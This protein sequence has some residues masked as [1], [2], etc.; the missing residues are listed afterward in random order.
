MLSWCIDDVSAS[1]KSV[2]VPSGS[3]TGA[4]RV[5]QLQNCHPEPYVMHLMVLLH[6]SQFPSL[7]A[8]EQGSSRDPSKRPPRAWD[9]VS[10]ASAAHK[11][12]STPPSSGTIRPFQ[13]F[14]ETPSWT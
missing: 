3:G 1:R 9:G 12:I 14:P 10:D 13:A 8:R 4:V 7:D 2:S 6:A 5:K 11:F